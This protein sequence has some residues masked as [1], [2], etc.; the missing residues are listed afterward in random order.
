MDR[1]NEAQCLAFLRPTSSSRRAIERIMYFL[2]LAYQDPT[3]SIPGRLAASGA[4]PPSS[5]A[6]NGPAMRVTNSA[7]AA[8]QRSQ[9]WRRNLNVAQAPV[10]WHAAKGLQKDELVLDQWG[11]AARAAAATA[12]SRELTPRA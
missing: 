12:S 4:L 5:F 9:H 2:N 3:G 10:H 11:D 8:R 1:S 7:L 6:E